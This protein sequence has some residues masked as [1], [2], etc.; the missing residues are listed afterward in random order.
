MPVPDPRA[1]RP[2]T[3][4]IDPSFP[5]L[6]MVAPGD[7]GIFSGHYERSFADSCASRIGQRLRDRP[8]IRDIQDN[9]AG[10][11]ALRFFDSLRPEGVGRADLHCRLSGITEKPAGP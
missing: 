10:I 6:E 3:S 4:D 2:D 9:P 11:G 1:A 5:K 8:G 7:A